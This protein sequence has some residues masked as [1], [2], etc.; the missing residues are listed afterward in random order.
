MPNQTGCLAGVAGG[1]QGFV[2]KQERAWEMGAAGR[3]GWGGLG[4]KDSRQW[5][6]RAGLGVVAHLLNALMQD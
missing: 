4:Q 6:V 3:R 2:M 5:E 1:W